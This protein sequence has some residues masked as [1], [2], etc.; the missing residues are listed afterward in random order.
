MRQGIVKGAPWQYH[1]TVIQTQERI[2]EEL[3]TLKRLTK[4]MNAQIAKSQ[5]YRIECV[6]HVVSIKANLK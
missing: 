1:V 6:V 2:L 3:M 5:F 4:L